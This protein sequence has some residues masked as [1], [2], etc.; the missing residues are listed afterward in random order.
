MTSPT[1]RATLLVALALVLAGCSG[2]ADQTSADPPATATAVASSP[3]ASA[4]AS[5]AP[6]E[7]QCQQTTYW[8]KQQTINW[9]RALSETDPSN[10]VL[11]GKDRA[12]AT[13][14]KGMPVQV[15]FWDVVL[16]SIAGRVSYELKPAQRKQVTVDG[17]KL[18]TVKAPKDFRADG[19]GGTLTAVYV[20]KP[21]TEN[22]LPAALDVEQASSTAEFNS[23]RVAFSAATMPGTGDELRSCHPTA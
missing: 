5:S 6:A 19:C 11:L 3:V 14:C 12:V 22:E 17:R 18:V 15:E 7:A 13:I 4:P 10:N 16:T 21:L 2:G 23:E 8:S 9:V 1:G 20:G